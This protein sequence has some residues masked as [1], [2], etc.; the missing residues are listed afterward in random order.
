MEETIIAHLRDAPA[1][2][3]VANGLPDDRNI[4]ECLGLAKKEVMLATKLQG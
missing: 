1:V 3:A 4:Q 2:A